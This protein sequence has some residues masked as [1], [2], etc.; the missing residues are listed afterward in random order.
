VFWG[1]VGPFWGVV[2]IGGVFG[3]VFWLMFGLAGGTKYRP[4]TEARLV[5]HHDLMFGLAFGLAF[6]LVFWLSF[7]LSF[8]LGGGLL[9]GLT[10]GLMFGLTAGHA[11]CRFACGAVLLALRRVFPPRP[12]S[13]LDWAYRAGLLRSTGG[14]Y[15][16]RH[17]TFQRWL[18]DHPTPPGGP[19]SL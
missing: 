8:G 13:F 1:V 14:A 15:Q 9:F 10:G 7:W 17:D 3:G 11:S 16:F 4:P 18:T 19:L 5:I 6:G 2:G 12:T